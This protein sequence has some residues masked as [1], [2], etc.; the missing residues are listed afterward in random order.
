MC[1]DRGRFVYEDGIITR[2]SR[3]GRRS[4]DDE[5]A[6]VAE[7]QQGDASAGSTQ[8]SERELRTPENDGGEAREVD[9]RSDEVTQADTAGAAVGGV[10]AEDNDTQVTQ[11]DTAGAAVGGVTAEDNNDTQVTQADTA[12]AAVGGV[13]AEDNNN[14]TQVRGR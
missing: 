7:Q 14:D 10:T 8:V 5:T 3:Q 9:G 11:A 6:H 1:D 13:T 2:T 4:C 12:G